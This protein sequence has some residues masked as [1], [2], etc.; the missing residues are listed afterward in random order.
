MSLVN[1][2]VGNPVK[3]AVGVLL[4]ALFGAIALDR[5]PMQL[6]PEVSTP[7]ITIETSWP[8][9]SPQEVEREI[10]LEQ[11][12]Q[13]K[14]VEGVIKMSSECMDS[15]GRI[16]LEFN[17]TQDMQEALVKVNARLQQVR[18]YPDDA[19]EPVLSTTSSA[20]QPIAWLI[21]RPRLPND[22]ELRAFI[23]DYP[24]LEETPCDPCAWPDPAPCG[25]SGS[26]PWRR[27]TRGFRRC[28]LRRAT[29]RRS[30]SSSRTTVEARFER[31]RRSGEFERARRSA[32]EEFQI[33]DRSPAVWP[34]RGAHDRADTRRPWR[35][36]QHRRLG[37]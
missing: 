37:R 35:R 33:V 10:V 9:A 1:T 21:L 2:F 36:S 6:T 4:V 34:S 30:S 31:V 8:G 13:L 7:E 24:A 12:E 14:G 15:M 29:S 3:V 11:E 26:P 5:M 19:L 18:E 23:A 32:N 20:E 22:E 17:V 27:P 25:S 28:S 16:T